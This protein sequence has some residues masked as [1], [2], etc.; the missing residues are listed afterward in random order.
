MNQ[1]YVPIRLAHRMLGEQLTVECDPKKIV[2]RISARLRPSLSRRYFV[3]GGDW[4]LNPDVLQ[5]QL[6]YREIAEMFRNNHVAKNC[7]TF[8]EAMNDIKSGKLVQFRDLVMRNEEDVLCYYRRL[9]ALISSIAEHGY[10]RQEQLARKNLGSHFDDGIRLPG[11]RRTESEIGVAIGRIGEYLFFK[12][13]HHRLAIAAMLGLK[14]VPVEIRFVHTGW[15]VDRLNKM[16]HSS[17]EDLIMELS[18]RE[19]SLHDH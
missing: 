5:T 3:V 15:L 4:D 12:K 17:L 8:R 16:R 9:S 1:N 19:E 10:Q 7:R 6:H 18:A 13:G 2:H 11:G 14:R